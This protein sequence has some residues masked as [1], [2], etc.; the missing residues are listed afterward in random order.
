MQMQKLKEKDEQIIIP[1][2]KIENI[3]QQ[4]TPTRWKID[5]QLK[6]SDI[7]IDKI[8]EISRKKK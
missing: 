2:K 1:R 8:I 5:K 7:D 4:P 6:W 3:S